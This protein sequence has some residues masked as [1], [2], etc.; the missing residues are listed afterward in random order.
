M[1][2][3]S[4]AT[5][6]ARGPATALSVAIGRKYDQPLGEAFRVEFAYRLVAS[7]PGYVA[8]E[9]NAPRGPLGTTDNRIMLE[10]VPLEPG[11]A[12]LHLRYA[13]EFGLEARLA[14][15]AYLATTGSGKVGFTT[16]EAPGAREPRFIGGMRGT[17]ERNTMRY[18]LAIDA[19]LGTLAAP[20][21]QRFEQS[22][23]RWYLATERYARQLHDV[24]RATYLE[25]KRR[26]YQRQQTL[27]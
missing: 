18:Y 11:R 25:M 2:M 17:I 23:E 7:S 12:F 14:M 5:R 20:P 6:C 24:D 13:H 16:I 1:S 22:I 9:F 8:V 15:D 3:S 26:E 4:T 10:A 21:A 19:Y 27:L